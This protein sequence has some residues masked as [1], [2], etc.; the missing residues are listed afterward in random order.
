MDATKARF[1]T[2]T[3]IDSDNFHVITNNTT[4]RSHPSFKTIEEVKYGY[5]GNEVMILPITNHSNDITMIVECRVILEADGSLNKGNRSRKDRSLDSNS[6]DSDHMDEI[7]SS[8]QGPAKGI[9]IIKGG[10]NA[11][12]EFTFKIL[13]EF[14]KKRVEI[15]SSKKDAIINGKTGKNLINLLGEIMKMKTLVQ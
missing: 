9:S 13:M 10:F 15:I 1:L 12:D 7:G 2:K 3:T 8:T 14:V 5:R 4:I 11:L 6:D